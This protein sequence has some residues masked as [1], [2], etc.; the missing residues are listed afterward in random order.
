MVYVALGSNKGDRLG[1]LKKA[2]NE[3]NKQ[4]DC[5]VEKTGGVYET[6]AYGNIKQKNF[7][8]T[9]ALIKT[10]LSQMELL[11]LLKEL[12]IKIGRTGSER[13]GP[14]EIDIDILFFDDLIYSNDE[15]TIPHK[16][17]EK[18]DFVLIPLAD[19][20]DKFIHPVL[21]KSI[22]VLLKETGGGNIIKKISG[23]IF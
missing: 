10:N 17:V 22:E 12:E 21:N 6:K 20:N 8:N 15:L 19:I 13:W 7:Y 23:K 1:Y 14:R 5:E 9:A 4:S 3:I 11:L 2:L 16:E 18:R